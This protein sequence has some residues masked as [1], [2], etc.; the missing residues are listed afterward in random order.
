MVIKITK[1]TAMILYTEGKSGRGMSRSKG[2][3]EGDLSGEGGERR[4]G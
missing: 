4:G 3:K 1:S 2:S